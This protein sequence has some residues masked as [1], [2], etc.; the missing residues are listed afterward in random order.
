MPIN[1]TM[2]SFSDRLAQRDDYVMPT[3]IRPDPLRSA[4][5]L[6][7]RPTP[8]AEVPEDQGMV[9]RDGTMKSEEGYLGPI[10]DELGRTMTE[11]SIGIP[12][13]Q[14]D[15]SEK[16]M[17][18]PSL[19][20]GLTQEEIDILKKDPEDLPES[21]RIKAAK[22]AEDR[23]KEGKSVFFSEEDKVTT[24]GVDL[25]EKPI[26]SKAIYDDR[27]VATDDG[28]AVATPPDSDKVYEA[29]LEDEGKSGDTTGVAETGLRGLTT[30]QYERQKR[31]N[32]NPNLSQ[33]EASKLYL[34]ELDTSFST[35]VEGYD[36]LNVNVKQD[37]LKESYNLGEGVTKFPGLK[38]A[39]KEG[40]VEKIFFSLLDTANTEGQS[41]KG[42][43]VRR[44]K[45]YNKHV[46]EKITEVEQLKDGTL[47]YKSKD[48][49]VFKYKPTKGKHKTSNPGKVNL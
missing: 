20:P 19:V 23:L 16:E 43:A 39:I 40:N 12:I 17:D 25:S 47:I 11:Y 3:E 8:T 2:T 45:V 44:A 35:N 4:Q 31:I 33:E 18:V 14:P 42:L 49:E 1:I 6:I 41:S 5:E 38:A 27:N 34:K 30:K 22:H 15:G 32:N 37:L 24:Q 9:R 28:K 21:I 48:K 7:Q 46:S 13:R 29:L 26:Q 10:K 36:N